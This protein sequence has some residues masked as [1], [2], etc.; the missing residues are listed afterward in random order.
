[1]STVPAMPPIPAESMT[2]VPPPTA[3]APTIPDDML[4]EVV[5]GQVVEKTM[6]TF[7]TDI[8]SLLVEI[9]GPF[10]RAN[11]LGQVFSE[12]LF[13]IYRRGSPAPSRRRVRVPC[14]L[15]L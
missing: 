1:M 11:R 6:G 13:R 2:P 10:A 12:M 3:L 5:D 15:A 7:E 14:P 8:A 4:Y 9:L